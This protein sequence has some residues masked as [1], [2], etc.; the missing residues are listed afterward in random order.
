MNDVKVMNVKT[1]TVLIEDI[2]IDVPHGV[3]VSISSEK[4][5]RSKDL[6]RLISQRLLFRFHGG[7]IHTASP[8]P[9]PAAPV[10]SPVEPQVVPLPAATPVV[11]AAAPPAG[12]EEQNRLLREEI[13]VRDEAFAA[14][15]LAQQ[16]R[17]DELLSLVRGLA[18]GGVSSAAPTANRKGRPVAGPSGDAPLFIP[19]TIKSVDMDDH[20]S[21]QTNEGEGVSSAAS[22]LKKLREKGA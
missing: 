1:G 18:A 5:L 3:V 9:T 8:N 17:F 13:G 6:W 14:A 19:S 2:T 16:G 12:L 10:L 4:A 7:P 22:A 20:V 11:P 21:V 15:L